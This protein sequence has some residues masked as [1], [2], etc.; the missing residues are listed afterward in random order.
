MLRHMMLMLAVTVPL[1][2]PAAGVTPAQICQ[3]SKNKAAGKYD[4]CRQKAEAKYG[5][6]GDG[7]ARRG[8]RRCRSASRSTT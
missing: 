6:N 1:A 2:V 4:Y 5:L 7:A 8:R 3:S